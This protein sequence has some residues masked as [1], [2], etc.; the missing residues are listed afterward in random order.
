MHFILDWVW[1]DF[2]KEGQE[3]LLLHCDKMICGSATNKAVKNIRLFKYY[4]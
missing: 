3:V 1:L 2:K 4:L